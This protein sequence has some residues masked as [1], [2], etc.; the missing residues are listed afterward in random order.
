MTNLSKF[1]KLT[2]NLLNHHPTITSTYDS[3]KKE[4]KIFRLDFDYGGYGITIRLDLLPL[5]GIIII[6]DGDGSYHFFEDEMDKVIKILKTTYI[7]FL[8]EGI[9]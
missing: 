6:R 3:D 9:E 5:H 2:L 4:Y 8:V 1:Y 7:D